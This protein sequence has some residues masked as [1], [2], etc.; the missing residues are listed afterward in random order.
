MRYRIYLKNHTPK[1]FQLCS[2][3][4]VKSSLVDRLLRRSVSLTLIEL[5]IVD[6]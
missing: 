5:R 4:P 6:N 2:L 3:F 1:D